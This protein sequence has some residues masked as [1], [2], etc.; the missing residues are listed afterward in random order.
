MAHGTTQRAASGWRAR[1]SGLAKNA[2]AR[3]VAIPAF[4]TPTSMEIVRFLAVLNL[5][6]RPTL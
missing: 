2:P 1:F 5:N 4:C 6:K 3:T